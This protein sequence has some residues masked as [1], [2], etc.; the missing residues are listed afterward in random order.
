MSAATRWSRSPHCDQWLIRG[1][2]V[3]GLWIGREKRV[4][5]DLDFVGRQPA[6][7]PFDTTVR[8]SINWLKTALAIDLPDQPSLNRWRFDVDALASEIIFGG[9][10]FPGVRVCVPV[11]D[12]DDALQIDI[13]FNDPL[14]L[15]P[16]ALSLTDKDQVLCPPAELAFAWK[17]HGLVEFEGM[18]WRTKDLSD[19]WL[20]L[21]YLPLDPTK[22]L[23]AIESSF[24][25]RDG[26]YWRLHR[27]L[28]ET[29]GQTAGSRRRWK[30]LCRDNPL[31]KYPELPDAIGS[32]AK[33]V[34]PLIEQLDDF[35]TQ[36]PMQPTT[37]GLTEL[38]SAV[39]DKSIRK[40]PWPDPQDHAVVVVCERATKQYLPNPIFAETSAKHQQFLLRREARGITFDQDGSLLA[41]PYASFCRLNELRVD[42]HDRFAEAEILEKLDGSLVF[43][44]R[45]P[46]SNGWC[47]R[48][49]RG[50]SEI[51]N[52][53]EQFA[54]SSSG[55]YSDLI[56]QLLDAGR[57]P[58][59]EWCSRS[60]LIVFDH[61]QDRLVLTGI[62]D[63]Q[64]GLLDNYS[65]L[66]TV[67]A[68]FGIEIPERFRTELSWTQ[69]VEH[70]QQWTDREGCIVRF[71]D[72]RQFKIKSDRY[73]WLHQAIEGS[74]K[75]AARWFLH[76]NGATD[77]LLHCSRG[78]NI[79]LDSYLQQLD[80]AMARLVDQA[81]EHARRFLPNNSRNRQ[82]LAR[83]IQFLP[84]TKSRF[85]FLAFD[86][87]DVSLALRELIAQRCLSHSGFANL[88]KWLDGP[89]RDDG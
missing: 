10:P 88:V 75:D 16:T 60:R 79:D 26:P 82:K 78:R 53:A 29:L 47:F 65:E 24:V 40:Y 7:I 81:V 23:T 49:R 33:F 6:S 54:A 13:A 38:L 37:F 42:D 72:G 46:N 62:R 55:R 15:P 80:Q 5:Q 87:N 50:R 74:H 36:P 19:M 21:N 41:R 17:L 9:T 57:S 32:V 56:D 86:G 77:Q 73:L 61:P 43:P 31:A 35:A 85:I 44:T 63:H 11:A 84:K 48:T 66:Q 25:S 59:F 22:T 34:R 51:A 83:D 89:T 70:V 8:Q 69:W 12:S 71:P 68:E 14:P 20:M 58:M 30:K 18:R 39:D 27:L 2:F 28:N 3:T 64:S 1:S 67:Q 45:M 76:V 4:C 52:A